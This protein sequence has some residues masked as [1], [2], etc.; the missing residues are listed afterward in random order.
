MVTISPALQDKIERRARRAFS[1][2]DEGSSPRLHRISSLGKDRLNYRVPRSGK[3]TVEV[4][5]QGREIVV[6]PPTTGLIDVLKREDFKRLKNNTDKPHAGEITIYLLVDKAKKVGK[7]YKKADKLLSRAQCI[8]EV[9]AGQY[10]Y[11][12]DLKGDTVESFEHDHLMA[13]GFTITSEL[14]PVKDLGL[15]DGELDLL[16][17]SDFRRIK[18]H[19]GVVRA[20]MVVDGNTTYRFPATYRD[21]PEPHAP[22]KSRAQCEDQVKEGDHVY[23][24]GV[25]WDDLRFIADDAEE[26]SANEFAV[27][28]ELDP[29]KDLGFTR[30]LFDLLTKAD[31]EALRKK[32]HF[33]RVRAYKYV[34]KEAKSPTRTG[35]DA[36][37]Y[38]V[39]DDYEIKDANTDPTSGCHTGINV[40]DVAWAKDNATGDRRLFAFEFEMADVA[41][42]PTHTDGKFR[43]HRCKCVAELDP[44][45][46]KPLAPA[47]RALESGGKAPEKKKKGFFDKLMGRGNDEA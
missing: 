7:T 9:K 41:A 8:A 22:L 16:T 44:K 43:V 32:R 29:E 35:T 38:K 20:Y 4:V 46:L 24:V 1:R 39:G 14:D 3:K 10:V 26:F 30:G 34:T 28:A 13:G 37:T 15:T 42:I 19:V 40:A 2:F 23:V 25:D 45:T 12:V 17:K 27:T 18:K 33:G 31:V 47:K 21:N 11:A 6:D 36:I 5:R